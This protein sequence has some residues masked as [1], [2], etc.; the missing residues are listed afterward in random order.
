MAIVKAA[1]GKST[2]Q[3]GYNPIA[4]V[5]SDGIVNIKDLAFVTQKLPAGTVCP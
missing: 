5:N 2:G 3:P 4:D 1:F